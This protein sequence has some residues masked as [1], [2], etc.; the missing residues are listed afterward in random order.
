MCN[1]C[2]SWLQDDV[3]SFLE[4]VLPYE[5]FALRLPKCE[6]P[7]LDGVLRSISTAEVARLQVCLLVPA[8]QYALPV[9]YNR[10]C[11]NGH[12]HASSHTVSVLANLPTASSAEH[13]SCAALLLLRCWQWCCAAQWGLVDYHRA[14]VWEGGWGRE[15]PGEPYGVAY[16]WCA[17]WHSRQWIRQREGASIG[18]QDVHGC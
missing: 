9:M 1:T 4:S 6:I 5:R 8:P 10:P 17:I 2:S 14:F 12:L 11:H 18:W 13:R 16:N 7:Q 3:Q 15:Y